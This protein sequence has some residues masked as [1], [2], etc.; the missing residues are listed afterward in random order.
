[1]QRL[2]L[3][4]ALMNDPELV[5]LDEPTDGVDPVGRRAIR[6]LLTELKDAGTTVFLNSHLL[7]EVELV[8]DRVAILI[9][10]LVARQ[11]TLSELTEHTLAYQIQCGKGVD[12]A[13]EQLAVMDAKIEGAKITITGHDAERVN[14]A[15]DILR[16]HGVLIES[17]HPHRLS[18]EDVF[19]E[20]MATTKSPPTR[21]GKVAP[22]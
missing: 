22:T 2:G 19:V 12:R 18:L 14:R 8:C 21:P 6:Q 13:A 10:G 7:S 11:G 4:Q 17:V 16:G 9:N 3:A 15:I 1:M 20:A 5:V